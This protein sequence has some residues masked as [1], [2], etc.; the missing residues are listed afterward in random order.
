MIIT[1][2]NNLFYSDEKDD[3]FL[4]NYDWPAECQ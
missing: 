3:A 2:N 1:F 4:L